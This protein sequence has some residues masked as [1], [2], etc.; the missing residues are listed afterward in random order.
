MIGE[1]LAQSVDRVLGMRLRQF[2]Q[3]TR[4]PVVFAGATRRGRSGP[5]LRIGHVRGVLGPGLVDLQVGRGRGLGGSVLA[6]H[7]LRVVHDYASTTSITHDFDDVVV[8]QEQL[9]SLFALPVLAAGGIRAVVY[10][11]VRGSQRIGDIVLDHATTFADSLRRDIDAATAPAPE[12]DPMPHTRL[13]LGELA[14]LSA[15]TD[16]PADRERLAALIAE[17]RAL[18]G[19]ERVP[20]PSNDS[21]PLAPREIDV[22]GLVAVGMTNREAAASLGLAE[23][24]VRAY[25]RSAMR[26][27]GVGNRTGAVHV[28]RSLG[29]L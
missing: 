24:T 29:Y 21:R 17:L 23:E 3:A 11:A 12:P 27:L 15:A 19:G 10:G 14:H 26:K 8:R 6:T 1:P 25:L 2:Q 20:T 9:G 4:L 13:A 22:L 16:D 5:E 7:E 28:A 18:T